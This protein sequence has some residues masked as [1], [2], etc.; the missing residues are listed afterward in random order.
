MAN[1]C[2]DAVR[3]DEAGG[4]WAYATGRRAA[5]GVCGAAGIRA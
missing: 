3:Q 1:D 4:G 2:R 5:F